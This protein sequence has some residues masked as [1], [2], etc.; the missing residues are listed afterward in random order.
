MSCRLAAGSCN[1]GQTTMFINIVFS[2]L[3]YDSLHVLMI[4]SSRNS[5]N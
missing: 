3:F 4:G 1:V 2:L 5:V